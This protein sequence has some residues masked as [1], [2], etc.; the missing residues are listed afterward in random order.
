[1]RAFGLI[2]TLAVSSLAASARAEEFPYQATVRTAEAQVVSGPGAE[3][4]P[5]QTLHNGDQVEVFREDAG[6]WCAIRPPQGSFSFVNALNVTAQEGHLGAITADRVPARVG[7]LLCDNR[8]AIH[9]YL[10]QGEKVHILDTSRDS[11][12]ETWC[13]IAPPP[14]EFRWLNKSNFTAPPAAAVTQAPQSPFAKTEPPAPPPRRSRYE[15]QAEVFAE[16]TARPVNKPELI[17]A[18]VDPAAAQKVELAAG[19][20]AGWFAVDGG[21]KVPLPATSAE[22][23]NPAN[24]STAGSLASANYAPSSATISVALQ[25]DLDQIDVAISR[26]VT[27][28]PARWNFTTIRQRTDALFDQ[29]ANTNE[30]SAV[31]AILN[32]LDRYDDLQKR[33]AQ[34]Q[35]AQA[36][37]GRITP[38]GLI[39]PSIAKSS[40]LIGPAFPTGY[41]PATNGRGSI[42]STPTGP[43]Q[44][45]PAQIS[46]FGAARP[47]LPAA[48]P[49]TMAA[50]SISANPGAAPPGTYDSIGKLTPVVSHRAGAPSFALINPS[51]EVVSFVTP[52]P[53]VDLQSYVGHEIGINGPKGYIP[54]F[55]KPHLT[56]Q[57]ATM[58]R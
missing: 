38:P 30:R 22:T 31:R 47:V 43:A 52:A 46:Q 53:G 29:A 34:F 51:G 5:T 24:R 12:G 21:Q 10:N 2:F 44:M 45:S 17:R 26:V 13:K 42:A 57:R 15:P 6:G 37:G 25:F 7:S 11:G 41:S 9:V 20:S 18:N 1:M 56:A 40:P 3:F 49:P 39:G 19:T 58:L 32:K 48:S 54:E 36:R 50:M 33:N 28:D 4:Y 27:Q 16:T 55:N 35:Q 8:D 23:P 14:G